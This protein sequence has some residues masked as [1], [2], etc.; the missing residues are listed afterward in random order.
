MTIL[1][2]RKCGDIWGCVEKDLKLRCKKC[3]LLGDISC[4]RNA[5]MPPKDLKA[6]SV[7]LCP[8]CSE[9]KTLF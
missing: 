5:F 3:S 2:C 8:S 7:G 4:P 9:K 1:K 6:I